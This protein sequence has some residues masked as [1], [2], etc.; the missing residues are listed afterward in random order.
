[1][2]QKLKTCKNVRA[3]I[4]IILN[5]VYDHTQA[6]SINLK[7]VQENGGHAD[8]GMILGP[9]SHSFTRQAWATP[10]NRFTSKD[11]GQEAQ[12]LCRTVSNIPYQSQYSS[13]QFI[14]QSA[15]HLSSD[16][17]MREEKIH[18][19][20]VQKAA[21]PKSLMPC[22]KKSNLVITNSHK[23][24]PWKPMTS[25]KNHHIQIRSDESL[26]HVRLFATP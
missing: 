14:Q 23:Q 6:F 15:Q 25:Y 2:A 7:A 19:S 10:G 16:S 22:R 18:F 20:Q 21:W 26:S 3:L 12:C 9:M 5:A 4:F 13:Q 8:Q 1:M 11:M 17:K 24:I